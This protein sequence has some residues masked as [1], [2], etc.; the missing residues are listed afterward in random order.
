MLELGQNLL[1]TSTARKRVTPQLKLRVITIK[2][3]PWNR[4]VCVNPTET[5]ARSWLTF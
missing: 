5:N 2:V 1:V 3:V 4:S